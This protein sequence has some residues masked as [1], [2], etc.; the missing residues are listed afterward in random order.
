MLGRA[1]WGPIGSF[2]ALQGLDYWK[3]MEQLFGL[4]M[5]LGVGLAFLRFLRRNLIPPEEDRSAGSLN[6]IGLVFLLI[7]MMWNNLYKNVR[8]W[9][10]GNHIPEY[11]FGIR[12]HWWFLIVGF[13]LSAIVLLAIIRHRRQQLPLAPSSAFGR[14]QL[15]F[16]IILWIAVVGA[17]VQAFPSMAHKGVF[18]VH[19]TFWLTAG[20]CSLIVLCLSGKPD[21]RL[22]PKLTASDNYWRPDMRHWIGWLLIPVLI[23]LLA[24]LTVSLDEEPLSGSHLRFE[25]TQQN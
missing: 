3:W 23:I 14:G 20:I 24:Y 18:F 6:T 7:V 12:S 2:S 25:K 10:K 11:F 8:N 22:E 21:Y 17:F 15:L 19:T 1:Q 13:L 5:G 9:A 16:L 4:I